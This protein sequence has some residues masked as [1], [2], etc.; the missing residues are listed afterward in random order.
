[1]CSSA[2]NKVGQ[3]VRPDVE[4]E[5]PDSFA[6]RCRRVLLALLLLSATLA[7][8]VFSLWFFVTHGNVGPVI[9][10]HYV[11]DK[12]CQGM[13]RAR[14]TKMFETQD[15]FFLKAYGV[16]SS[17][18][19]CTFTFDMV[20]DQQCFARSASLA[21]QNVSMQLLNT[22]ATCPQP[23]TGNLNLTG[24]MMGSLPLTDFPFFNSLS[25]N[26]A[27]F[28]NTSPAC[29]LNVSL[30]QDANTLAAPFL[31]INNQICPPIGISMARVIVTYS[32]R[33]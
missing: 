30:P 2:C 7:S 11:P 33:L 17:R 3:L 24:N 29:S 9:L 5:R 10:N 1:M 25:C 19:Q 12:A 14:V 23:G 27:C 13:S 31:I 6:D 20:S 15:N 26:F 16:E 18:Y 8:F 4:I 32:H 21:H 22:I 28:S